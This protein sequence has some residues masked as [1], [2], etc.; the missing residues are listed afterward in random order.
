MGTGGGSPPAPLVPVMHLNPLTGLAARQHLVY[1]GYYGSL[2]ELSI[3]LAAI[4]SSL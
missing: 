1:F 2:G 3:G 4:G